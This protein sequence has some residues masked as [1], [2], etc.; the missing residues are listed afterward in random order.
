MN[1]FQPSLTADRANMSLLSWAFLFAALAILLFYFPKSLVIA[2]TG[3]L[4]IG[5][6]AGG[7]KVQDIF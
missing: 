4:A 2:L 5:L 7:I 1:E 3:G 6:L